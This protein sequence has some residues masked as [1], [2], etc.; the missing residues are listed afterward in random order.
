MPLC[1]LVALAVVWPVAQH[2]MPSAEAEDEDV[3]Y[4]RLLVITNFDTTEV[5]ING[6]SYP[7]EWI[8]GETVSYTHLT[9][10]TKA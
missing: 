10:P 4:G 7:Y 6:V 1:L 8:W 5:E 9:L 2:W 3:E